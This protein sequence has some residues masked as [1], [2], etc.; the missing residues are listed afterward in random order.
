MADKS[1]IVGVEPSQAD[2]EMFQKISEKSVK[3]YENIFR[4]FYHIKS[5]AGEFKSLKEVDVPGPSSNSGTSLG[6]V[7]ECWIYPCLLSGLQTPILFWKTPFLVSVA[8]DSC[9]FS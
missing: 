8:S 6:K 7:D 2:V 9:L 1:Y 3:K 4:W 5:F